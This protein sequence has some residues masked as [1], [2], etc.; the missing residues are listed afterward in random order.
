MN[1]LN[2]LSLNKGT[3]EVNGVTLENLHDAM[4]Q[5]VEIEIATIPLY[6]NTYYSINRSPSK[7]DLKPVISQSLRALG[8]SMKSLLSTLMAVTEFSVLDDD[9]KQK[10]KELSDGSPSETD[11]TNLLSTVIIISANKIAAQI[12]SVFVEEMLHAALAANVLSGMET[13]KVSG[14]KS[15]EANFYF[16]GVLPSWPF[17]WAGHMPA[18]TLNLRPLSKE[19][20]FSFVDVET[21]SELPGFEELDG[22]DPIPFTTIGEF[23]GA[24][25]KV[26]SGND[27]HYRKDAPKLDPGK[28]YYAQNNIN[29]TYYGLEH[30]HIFENSEDAGD[31]IA[32]EG[33]KAKVEA[34]QALEL[35]VEQGEGTSAS[36][37]GRTINCSQNP[38]KENGELSHFVKF[39]RAYCLLSFLEEMGDMLGMDDIKSLFVFP[40]VDN[41][42]LAKTYSND[43]VTHSIAN[44][45]NAAFSYIFVMLDK[46]YKT[47]DT[48]EKDK[49]FISIHKSMMWV[50]S[51][52][53]QDLMPHV[54]YEHSGQT[55]SMSPTFEY[56][57][58]TK[59][60]DTPKT[61]I[62]AL[63]DYAKTQAMQGGT[64]HANFQ[65]IVNEM[66]KLHTRI[67]T[68]EDVELPYNLQ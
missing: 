19:Q 24:I 26:I 34:L 12:Y 30:Q 3:E 53:S 1:R 5:A 68:L 65:F 44:L 43:P 18:I 37:N 7:D 33:H 40:A 56:Y 20:L 6:L 58:F 36:W 50:I 46:C 54:T 61:Q 35:I 45:T 15:G 14:S 28:G 64:M 62:L 32:V 55:Y 39:K 48:D 57:D 2:F 66:E 23:Y 22:A 31:L 42:T 16:N 67:S 13:P 17:D 60:S 51:T 38:E 59:S 21:P 41:P 4:Q 9:I 27:I 29:S 47:E 10:F 49:V 52:L 8:I 25:M 11:V 63:V